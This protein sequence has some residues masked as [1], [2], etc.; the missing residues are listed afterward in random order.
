MEGFQQFIEKYISSSKVKNWKQVT[1]KIMNLKKKYMGKGKENK[2]FSSDHD[3]KFLKLA[4]LIWGSDGFYVKK[5]NVKSR[6][7]ERSKTKKKLEED[8]FEKSFVI[9]KISKMGVD[10]EIVKG[11]WS[12]V[13]AK[14]RKKIEEELTKLEIEQIGFVLRKTKFL[15]QATSATAESNQECIF[16]F[17]LM[18]FWFF[19]FFWSDFYV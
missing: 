11:R 9:R 2:S 13:P 6:E 10:E 18:N 14:K 12:M 19:F 15:R 16:D 17:Q 5:S 1:T 3:H 7:S 8:R 4:K